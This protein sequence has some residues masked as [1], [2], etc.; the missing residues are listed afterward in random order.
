MINKNEIVP[1]QATD[2]LTLYGTTLKIANISAE[3]LTGVDGAYQ[4][5]TNSKTYIADAPVK[6]LDIDATASS[7]TA[8][9]TYFVPDY[10]FEGVSKD[11]TKITAT[12]DPD[13]A[14][15]YKAVLDSGTVTVSKVGF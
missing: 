1:V 9:T 3:A 10:Y 11:G 8:N 2:L 15:L 6:T 7:V 12:V 5:K 14:T 13:G 4:V